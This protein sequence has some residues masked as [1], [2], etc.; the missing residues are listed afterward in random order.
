MADFRLSEEEYNLYIA[1]Y[2]LVGA[3][4]I[5]PWQNVYADIKKHEERDE[6][7]NGILIHLHS[8][9]GTI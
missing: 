9:N 4:E 6:K 1:I 8:K 7:L 2:D 5:F 3:F